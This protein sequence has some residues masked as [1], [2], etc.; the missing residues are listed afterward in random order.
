MIGRLRAEIRASIDQFF[1]FDDIRELT[2]VEIGL[3]IVVIFFAWGRFKDFGHE[4]AWKQAILATEKQSKSAH[5][6]KSSEKA[7][8]IPKK[9]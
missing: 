6:L 1:G 8:D 7:T 2:F 3:T 4:V 9:V 5:L